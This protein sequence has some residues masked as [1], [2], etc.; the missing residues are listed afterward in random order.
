MTCVKLSTAKYVNRPSPPYS[1][2]ACPDQTMK[3]NNGNLYKSVS[4]KNGV[5]RWVKT[6]VNHEVKR[7]H[8]SKKSSSKKKRASLKK[9]PSKKK[10]ASTKSGSSKKTKSGSNKHFI[11]KPML[12]ATLEDVQDVQFPTL[13]TEKIDGI[14]CLKIKGEFVSRT[15]KT[16][17]NQSIR[18]ALEKANLP[19][20]VDGEL[21]VEGGKFSDTTSFV[22]SKTKIGEDIIFYIFDYV[23][24][25]GLDEPYETRM[26]NLKQ[27]DIPTK[28][29]SDGT[30]V[31][32]KK[33]LPHRVK[34]VENLYKFQR[35]ALE[36]GF[37]GV[38]LRKPSSPYK[39]GRSTLRSNDLLKWKE[40][41]D[42]E[43]IIIDF[44]EAVQ[45]NNPKKM[46]EL[47]KMVRNHQKDGKIGM[48]TLGSLVVEAVTKSKQKK[49][50]FNIG[51]GFT[52]AERD[53]IWAHK[54]KYLGKIIKY[55]YF[56]KSKDGIPRFPTFIAERNKQD[57]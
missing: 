8:S 28:L 23:S 36:K 53:Y 49:A 34:D 52:D 44:E 32:I 25:A 7:K 50:V 33:Q 46:N 22:M 30:T 9:S 43:A 39:C 55:K 57:M 10:S 37:E 29:T 5:Y 35:R 40:F 15:F 6:T 13:C 18:N 48:D 56:E 16:I 38:C 20:N 41:M 3:G 47:G 2:Q 42:D 11:L 21:V 45:N 1:A 19:D 27:L 26:D 14:R 51:S 31:T 54:K 17:P 4:N 12:A 24:R